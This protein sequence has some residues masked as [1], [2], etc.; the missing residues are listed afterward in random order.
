[1][2]AHG[3]LYSHAF[4]RAIE[5]HNSL[6]AASDE[7]ALTLRLQPGIEGFLVTDTGDGWRDARGRT[8]DEI[9]RQEWEA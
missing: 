1:M 7:L 9:H 4:D 3:V 6:G 5:P 2:T 8:V